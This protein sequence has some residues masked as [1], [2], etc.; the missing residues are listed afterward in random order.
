MFQ[1]WKARKLQVLFFFSLNPSFWFFLSLQ[2]NSITLN[3]PFLNPKDIW[4]SL[5]T[6][7]FSLFFLSEF[8]KNLKEN[9][10]ISPQL[11]SLKT[12]GQEKK[13]GLLYS[14]NFLILHINPIK[15]SFFPILPPSHPSKLINV[16]LLF[17]CSI[18]FLSYIYFYYYYYFAWI[19]LQPGFFS[20]FPSNRKFHPQNLNLIPESRNNLGYFLLISYSLF[21]VTFLIWEFLHNT[22][23]IKIFLL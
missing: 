23:I 8:G 12:T 1:R 15:L 5:I 16:L 11:F 13:I 18:S 22:L 21:Q 4:N 14:L 2:N 3:H 19:R 6:P 10:R 20:F 7:N 17:F 9:S